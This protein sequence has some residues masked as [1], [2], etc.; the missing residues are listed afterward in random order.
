MI[1]LYNLKTKVCEECIL[2]NCCSFC[3]ANIGRNGEV[4]IDHNK[5]LEAINSFKDKLSMAYSALEI[6]DT[7]LAEFN[8]NYYKEVGKV[9]GK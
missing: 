1:N 7:W 4:F 2:K 3:F 6:N 8:S 5:C 9:Y